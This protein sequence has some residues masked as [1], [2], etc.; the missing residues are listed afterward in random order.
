MSP[1]VSRFSAPFLVTIGPR[2]GDGEVRRLASRPVIWRLQRWGTWF[3]ARF[4]GSSPFTKWVLRWPHAA[5]GELRCV[6]FPFA[7]LTAVLASAT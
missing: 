6:I 1:I 7:F 5:L 3:R 2:G 4:R